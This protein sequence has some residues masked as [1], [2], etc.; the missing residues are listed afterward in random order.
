MPVWGHHTFSQFQLLV[1]ALKT[2]SPLK[3]NIL[4]KLLMLY[5]IYNL[6]NKNAPQNLNLA[7]AD[8]LQNNSLRPQTTAL[9]PG[10]QKVQPGH[11]RHCMEDEQ[12]SIE[13]GRWEVMADKCDTAGQTEAPDP[14][15]FPSRVRNMQRRIQNTGESRYLGSPRHGFKRRL[16]QKEPKNQIH[17]RKNSFILNCRLQFRKTENKE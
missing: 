16:V 15:T 14:H 5:I 3:I 10:P 9:S 17:I 11:K 7:D 2:I 4:V 6:K 1:P 13:R 12:S 8:R